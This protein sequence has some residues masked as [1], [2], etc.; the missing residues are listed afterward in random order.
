MR[1]GDWRVGAGDTRSSCG[2]GQGEELEALPGEGACGE[3]LTE[4]QPGRHNRETPPGYRGPL[5]I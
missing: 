2:Q 1:Q 3:G 5:K 4:L